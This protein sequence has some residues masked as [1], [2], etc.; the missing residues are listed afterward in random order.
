MDRTEFLLALTAGVTTAPALIDEAT[1]PFLR[2]ERRGR[3]R[4]GV[5]AIDVRSGR[6]IVQRGSE[7]FPLASTF[8][9]PL[10]MAVLSRVDRGAERLERPIR[11]AKGDLLAYGPVAGRQPNGGSLTVAELCA[12]AIEYSDNAAANLLLRTVGGPA[13]LT[14]YLRGAGDTV[15]RLDRNEPALNEAVPGDVRDTTTPAAMATLVARLVR[16]PLL[17]PASKA[18][19]FGWLRASKTGAARIRAGV[20]HDWTVGDKTGT[21]DSGGNDVAILWPRTGAPIVLAVYFAEVHAS[22]T[23]RDAAIADVARTVV[24]RLRT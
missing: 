21:S 22:D 4:L 8:K 5:T 24:H 10:T 15:T 1:S 20:P 7:R 11:F 3:G 12:A 18:L 9:L 6:R 14:A 17:E 16:E 2:E 13:G 19:L 23:E